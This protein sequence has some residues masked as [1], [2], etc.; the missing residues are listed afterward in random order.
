MN[1]KV[2][3]EFVRIIM[4]QTNYDEN[5]AKKKLKEWDNN[6]ANVIKEYLNPNFKKKRMKMKAYLQ[7]K[8]YF[9]L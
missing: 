1:K 3:N 6:F 5:L 8:K 2:E 4:N 9:L 7:I